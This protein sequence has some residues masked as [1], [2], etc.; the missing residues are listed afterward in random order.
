PSRRQSRGG[1]RT[2][3]SRDD[4]KEEVPARPRSGR[5]V[6]S[7]SRTTRVAAGVC[8]VPAPHGVA[9]GFLPWKAGECRA[10]EGRVN[11]RDEY[12]PTSSSCDRTTLDLLAMPLTPSLRN[13]KP[14]QLQQP[15]D[16]LGGEAG[17]PT[18]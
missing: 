14:D 12:D 17:S 8:P 9:G 2:S 13:P 3:G 10:A 6:P 16:D 1:R 4:L 11:E 18:A 7:R 15:S 5:G